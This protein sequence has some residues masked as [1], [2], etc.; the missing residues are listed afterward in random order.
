MSAGRILV[1]DDD[2]EMCALLDAGLAKR[3]FEV[4]TRTSGDAAIALLDHS[5]FDAIV[6]DLNM[7][8]T[9]GLDVSTWV[10]ANRADT[11]VVVITAFGTLETAVASIRA[12]A[13]DFVTKPFELGAVAL[14][15]DRAV[16]YCR[17]RSEVR[18]LRLAA[19]ADQ[20]DFDQIGLPGTALIG[21]SPAMRRTFDTI[22]RAA[23]TDA[24][25]LV[26]GESGT[27]KE[28]VARAL[29]DRGRR[30]GG[31]FIAVNC[32]AMPESLLESELFGHVRGSFTDARAGRTG[33]L[34]RATGGT[35]F[36]D[37]IGEAPPALQSKLLRA[38]EER[39][40]RPVGGDD[41]RPFDVRLVCATNRDLDAE[42]ENH[43]FRSDLYYRI[44]VIRIDLPP[45]RA[46]GDDVLLL[47]QR[48]VKQ[49][50]AATEKNVV[51]IA[52]AA[53][54][55]L[56]A[57]AWPGN[58]RELRNCIERAVAL[59]RFAEITVADL[60]EPIQNYQRTR[61]VLDLDDPGTLPPL[62]EVERRYILRV[63]E[64]VNGHRTRAA[65]VLGL[66]RKTLY[67]KLERYGV[68]DGEE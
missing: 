30:A 56:L 59:T 57:Y 55:K 19:A 23:A 41:D 60:P 65:E 1:V 67:R 20:M 39:R 68:G 45:L 8:G 5:D 29:H 63:L 34:L 4:T 18:R 42:I 44:N 47:A 10:A 46:R 26:T 28:L 9:S 49:T 3:G 32:G 53:A 12:G 21:R 22:L 62:E 13:Y 24:S 51:G 52:T 15:L 37:E 50:A 40:V 64:A 11:P 35:L 16:G 25:V 17:L 27:G 2:A 48:M 54:E 38:L 36:L 66:D 58:V 6:V 14:T 7:P 61:M 33:L 31:P 43:R